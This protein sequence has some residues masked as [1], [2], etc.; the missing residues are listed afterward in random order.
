[1]PLLTQTGKLQREDLY[2][3]YPHY[4]H[5]GFKPGAAIISGQYKLIEW[6]EPYLA[7]E[8]GAVSLFDITKDPGETNDLADTMPDKAKEL[9]DKLHQWQKNVGAQS[10]T[11]NPHFDEKKRDWRFSDKKG[12]D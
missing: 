11:L 12:D 1:M 8:K 4:H 5:L 2:W 7:K 3:H 9:Q 10:M 6:F